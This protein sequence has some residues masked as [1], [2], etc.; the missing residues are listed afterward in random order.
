MEWNKLEGVIRRI[1]AAEPTEYFLQELTKRRW[2]R[3]RNAEIDDI[4]AVL[5]E[6]TNVDLTALEG[7]GVSKPTKEDIRESVEAIFRTEKEA[8]PKDAQLF[9]K[10]GMAVH[11]REL[12][13]Q[14]KRDALRAKAELIQKQRD[15]ESQ[16]DQLQ[17]QQEQVERERDL[18]DRQLADLNRPKKRTATRSGKAVK[19][20]N[21]ALSRSGTI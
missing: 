3:K 12:W 4:V 11:P 7:Y 14:D 19:R 1:K 17:R 5:M 10:V 16:R 15:L 2:G 9:K 18:V 13:C 6:W 21:E 20:I 8:L